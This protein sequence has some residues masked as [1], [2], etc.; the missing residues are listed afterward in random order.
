MQQQPCDQ[1]HRSGQDGGRHHGGG[2][3]GGVDGVDGEEEEGDAEERPGHK[4]ARVLL[5]GDQVPP[6]L[7]QL[8]HILVWAHLPHIHSHLGFILTLN[9]RYFGQK[10]PSPR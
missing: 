1:Q 7:A 10:D 5:E 4:V 9:L 8:G 6:V 3:G 2:Q